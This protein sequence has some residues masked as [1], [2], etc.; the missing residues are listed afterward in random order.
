MRGMLSPQ[1]TQDI[2]QRVENKSSI[3]GAEVE[4]GHSP[5]TQECQECN[6]P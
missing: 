1:N 6:Y 2:E 4:G 3:E 5:W